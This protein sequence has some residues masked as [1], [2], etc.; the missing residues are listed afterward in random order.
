[1]QK[2]RKKTTSD[3]EEVLRYAKRFKERYH[4]LSHHMQKL[5]DL[6]GMKKLKD[7]VLSQI[8]FL[9][10]NKDSTDDH[11]LHTL[12]IGPP[13]CGKTTVAQILFDI[14]KSIGIFDGGDTFS[15]LH[16]S[17]FVGNY[18]G[19]T[20]NKTR[21]TLKKYKGGCIFIDEFY[22]LVYGD[23]DDYGKEALDEICTFM[24][25]NK[26]T[27]VIAAGYADKIKNNIFSAQPGLKRRFAWVFEIEPY[28]SEELYAI[29]KT[30]LTKKE[31]SIH[32]KKGVQELFRTHKD[33]FQFAGGD[34]EN[35]VF[36]SKINYSK[37]RWKNPG[38]KRL[39]L[40]DVRHAIEEHFVDTQT[41]I[42]NM[43]I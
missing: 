40:K 10:C 17:D 8:K 24:S 6:V 9:L 12:I 26:D 20:S 37:R 42:K 31:W 29:F 36:K 28:T 43:Y 11:F 5:K 4:N 33:K 7:A 2:K 25:E 32:N 18:M 3:F 34:T 30:Q 39:R 15:I 21:K 27:V 23:R 19:Q 14:W 22:S 13:G 1:M 38:R 16:R 41:F 35:I